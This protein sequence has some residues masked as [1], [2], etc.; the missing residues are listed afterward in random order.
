MLISH[1]VSASGGLCS[2]TPYGG[3]ALYPTGGLPSPGGP[4][5]PDHHVN[6]LHCTILGYAYVS[7][8]QF[9]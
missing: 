4:R 1:F 9:H 3:F 5:G 2:Q 7:S 8:L 6:P